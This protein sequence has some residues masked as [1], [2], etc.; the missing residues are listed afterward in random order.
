MYTY[1]QVEREKGTHSIYTERDKHIERNEYQL[2]SVLISLQY[3]QVSAMS[4][5]LIDVA[6]PVAGTFCRSACPAAVSRYTTW[7]N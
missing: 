7:P 6:W 2:I 3:L 1:I 4:L 5:K